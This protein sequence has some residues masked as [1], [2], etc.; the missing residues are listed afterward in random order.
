MNPAYG[1]AWA[2]LGMGLYVLGVV[3]LIVGLTWMGKQKGKQ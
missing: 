3:G 2:W 1:V